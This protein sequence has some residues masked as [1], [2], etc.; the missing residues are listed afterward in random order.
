MEKV[1]QHNR[2]PVSKPF[3]VR[4]INKS[5]NSRYLNIGTV[6]PEGWTHVKVIVEELTGD[7]CVLKLELI[8]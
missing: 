5:G 3:T 7:V 6:I 2:P 1:K 4:R 8:K